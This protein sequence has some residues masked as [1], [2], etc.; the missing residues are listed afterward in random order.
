[1]TQQPWMSIVG[2]ANRARKLISGE[3][4]VLK[5]IR[6]HRAKLVLLSMDASANTKK[7]IEDKCR[8]Y[9][10]PIK[11]VENRYVLGK[12]IGKEARVVIAILDRGFS[13]KLM[14]LLD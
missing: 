7:R 4:L 6:Q 10:V 8:Y 12:S 9:E 5:E 1:M 3:E 2:L 14:Q 11:Y 13:E